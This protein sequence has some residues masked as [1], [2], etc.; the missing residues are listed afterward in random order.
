MAKPANPYRQ[1]LG[2]IRV[3][4]FAPVYILSG[5]TPYYLDLIADALM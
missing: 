2:E 3:R 4:R 5:E 1:I